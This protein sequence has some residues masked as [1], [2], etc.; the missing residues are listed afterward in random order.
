V[1]GPGHPLREGPTR[2]GRH[3]YDLPNGSTIVVGGLDEPT[4]LLSTPWDLI[5]VNEATEIA[6]ELWEE[7]GGALRWNRVP[8]Q[9]R[10]G[11]CNPVAPGHW[12]NQ[13]ADAFP[14]ALR[15]RVPDPA[16]MAERLTRQHYDRV[17]EHNYAPLVGRTKRIVTYHADNPGYWDFQAWDWTETGRQYV[18]KQLATMGGHRRKRFFE[19]IWAGAEGTVYQ[20]F[21]EDR[22]VIRPFRIPDGTNDESRWPIIVGYD[23]GY[24]HPC[25]VLWFAVSPNE[26]LYVIDEIYGGGIDIP[27]LNE[28]IHQKNAY[29]TVTRFL[30]DP[31]D[32][33][34]RRQQGP[35]IADQFRRA[36]YPIHFSPWPRTAQNAQ[37]MVEA[38]RQRLI[39]GKL[40][41][42]ST[43][44]NA[45]REHQ[46][47][48]Y[49][50]TTTGELPAGDDAYEDR[51]NHTCDV[52]KGVVAA[53]P[54]Y[55]SHRII[56]Q[57]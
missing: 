48:S 18:Q 52:V 40:K 55:E 51:D 6:E 45:I 37:S 25:A 21:D 4:R 33:F 9:Q 47:W 32:V 15:P 14:R 1:L 27:R 29:R 13:R 3:A 44:A 5:Y 35:T 11:D 38:V 20:E 46:S 8:W 30:A 24:D 2:A 49:K 41:F 53:N 16:R 31:Q 28:L 54:R 42:F 23:S 57:G 56:V 7:M 22:H 12:M 43:C 34:S 10:I 17:Q 19:G 39:N 36:R 26:T 50:R